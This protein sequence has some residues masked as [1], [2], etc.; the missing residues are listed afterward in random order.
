MN[1]KQRARIEQRALW[2]IQTVN[3]ILP[4]LE[5]QHFTRK[6]LIET[7]AKYRLH[8]MNFKERARI[9]QRALWSIQTVNMILPGLEMQHFTRK[10]LIET[11]A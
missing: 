8:T 2:S 7:Q 6:C 10:C 9:E 4:G 3:M 11:Q 5:M 1:F